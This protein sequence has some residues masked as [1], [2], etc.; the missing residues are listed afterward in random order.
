MLSRL[1]FSSLNR[2]WT[3]L[4]FII[5]F[6]KCQNA[7]LRLFSQVWWRTIS[8]RSGALYRQTPALKT[9]ASWCVSRNSDRSSQTDGQQ[10]RSVAQGW[11]QIFV[12]SLKRN[13]MYEWV[14]ASLS[15]CMPVPLHC[16]GNKLLQCCHL[17][18]GTY[19]NAQWCH[20]R[21]QKWTVWRVTSWQLCHVT[22]I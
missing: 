14:V 10:T 21:Y 22:W 6:I 1:A 4:T 18:H 15:H 13:V 8:L 17:S 3:L 16:G 5:G 7:R 2:D 20:D 12:K 11:L 9:C 19:T